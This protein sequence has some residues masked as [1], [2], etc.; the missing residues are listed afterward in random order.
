MG[1]GIA[2]WLSSRG[3]RVILKDVGPEPLGK[4]MQ[5]V[6]KTYRDAVKR[7]LFS[8]TDARNAFD[9]VLPVYEEIPL[10]EVDLVLE[11]A[12]EKLDLK[13]QI[14]ADI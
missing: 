8:E 9:R 10:R 5:S 12:V 1:A 11:A 13:Q 7:H 2:Q 6:A 3:V 4:A 14:F